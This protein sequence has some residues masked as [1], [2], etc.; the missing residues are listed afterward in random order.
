MNIAKSVEVLQKARNELAEQL[1]K[2]DSKL[3]AAT[4]KLASLD[5]NILPDKDKQC[6]RLVAAVKKADKDYADSG[7]CVFA[8]KS[9][10]KLGGPGYLVQMERQDIKPLNV[11]YNNDSDDGTSDDDKGG[12]QRSASHAQHSRE[13]PYTAFDIFPKGE[14]SKPTSGAAVAESGT[15]SR[16][17]TSHPE[18]RK[19][20]KARETSKMAA[21]IENSLL[22]YSEVGTPVTAAD[23]LAL[24]ATKKAEQ[25]ALA[26]L[27]SID[28][29]EASVPNLAK[30][31]HNTIQELRALE[32]YIFAYWCS[33]KLYKQQQHSA[34]STV[35]NQLQA[36]A[37]ATLNWKW[38]TKSRQRDSMLQLIH[39]VGKSGDKEAI[40]FSPKFPDD[41]SLDELCAQHGLQHDGGSFYVTGPGYPQD[42]SCVHHTM[43]SA[44]RDNNMWS[45]TEICAKL[46]TVKG[47]LI[48]SHPPSTYDQLSNSDGTTTLNT[49]VVPVRE[50]STGQI[51]DDL[52]IE[53]L[54]SDLTGTKC[55]HTASTR[56]LGTATSRSQ[57]PTVPAPRSLRSSPSGG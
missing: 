8:A 57:T 11:Y 18:S 6:R 48:Y 56:S 1:S 36:S 53:R 35:A 16:R 4:T 51:D 15:K 38:T 3:T 9:S 5:D 28:G 27:R 12:K 49:Y 25:Q 47:K 32:K 22:P 33:Y 10:T 21:A 34:G 52:C 23:R 46:Y 29:S 31:W 13:A 43:M 41:G 45:L 37:F 7:H 24:R 40:D 44:I 26:A 14:G 30:H 42:I 54:I 19:A 2:A 55:M 39:K 50:T 20:K 17:L